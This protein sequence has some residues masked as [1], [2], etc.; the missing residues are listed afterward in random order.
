[1]AAG[2]GA[3]LLTPRSPPPVLRLMEISGTTLRR[4]ALHV[5]FDG[6]EAL[7][8]SAHAPRCPRAPPRWYEFGW[9]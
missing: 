1:M 2:L 4:T 8:V 7:G 5:C 9:K 3:Q 6:E